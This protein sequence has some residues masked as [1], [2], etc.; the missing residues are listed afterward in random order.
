MRKHAAA[1]LA[2][3]TVAAL[4]AVL[5][6]PRM[7]LADTTSCSLTSSSY[8]NSVL[9]PP[10]GEDTDFFVNKGGIPNVMFL[11]DTSGSMLQLAPEG[12]SKSWGSF[13]NPA[14]GSAGN[15]YGCYNAYA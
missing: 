12:A 4:V 14:S 8:G 6:W 7:L 5:A 3:L 2:A 1:L 10:V 9:N 15:G 13:E 11:L